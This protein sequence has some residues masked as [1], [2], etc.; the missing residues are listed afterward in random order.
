MSCKVI[1]QHP[2]N[3]FPWSQYMPTTLFSCS[4]ELI[5]EV[6]RIFASPS[7]SIKHRGDVD[8]ILVS[9]IFKVIL[10]INT[11]LWLCVSDSDKRRAVL[12]DST[13]ILNERHTALSY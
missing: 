12:L 9:S 6:T 8:P 13:H 4:I 7:I 11:S 2:R 10:R 5:Y 3:F 1:P